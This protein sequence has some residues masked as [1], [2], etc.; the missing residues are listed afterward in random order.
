MLDESSLLVGTPRPAPPAVI[1]DSETGQKYVLPQV[2]VTLIADNLVIA[3]INGVA[4][5][6]IRRLE[7]RGVIPKQEEQSDGA[8]QKS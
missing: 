7:A 1:T 4:E 3:I 5:S 6:V 8:D 2:A